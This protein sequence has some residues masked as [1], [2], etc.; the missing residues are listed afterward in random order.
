MTKRNDFL[1]PVRHIAQ[2]LQSADLTLIN[3]ES[4]LIANCP[5]TNEGMSF[6]GDQRFVDALVFAGVDVASLANNHIL[7]HGWEGLEQTET[8]LHSKGIATTGLSNDLA[9]KKA[10][11]FFCDEVFPCDEASRLTIKTVQGVKVGFLGFTAVGKKLS[12][13]RLATQIR[14]ADSQVEV[15]VVSF[16][17]GAEYTR[18]PFGAPDDPQEIGRL[19]VENGADIVIGNHPHWIQGMSFDYAQDKEGNLQKKPIF[20]ALGNTIFDQEWSKETK[21]GIIAEIIFQGSKVV[22]IKLHP[23]RL[24]NYGEAELLEGEEKERLLKIFTDASTQLK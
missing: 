11:A 21:E 23:L 16:H 24:T 15:L 9:Q 2:L 5:L 10:M 22:D 20:Y 19:A 7:N 8:L 1:W 14:A 12:Q 4:P 13:D 17:W 6:C 18:K 3:L